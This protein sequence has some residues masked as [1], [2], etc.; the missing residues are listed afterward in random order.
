LNASIRRK[1][2]SNFLKAAR[3]HWKTSV[4][5]IAAGLLVVAQSYQSGMTWKQWALA[6]ALAIGG[7]AAQDAQTKPAA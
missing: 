1:N 7:A 3:T 4:A 2:V 5:G 6:A